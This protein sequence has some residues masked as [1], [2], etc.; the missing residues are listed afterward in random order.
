[1]TGRQITVTDST[2]IRTHMN[3]P[4]SFSDLTVG[5]MV[6]VH[7]RLQ[8]DS[9]L[10]AT[11][12]HIEDGQE[13]RVTG[14][15]DVINGDT[16]VVGGMDFITE[17]TTLYF[18]LAHQP[19]SFPDITTGMV[20]EV[21]A[22]L[23]AD[24]Y[25]HAVRV[26]IEDDPSMQKVTGM[27]TMIGSNWIGISNPN[28]AVNTATV[29]L[30]EQFQPIAFSELLI[31]QTVTLWADAAMMA[32]QIHKTTGTT[33]GLENNDLQALP[34]SFVLGANYPN[35]F[36]PTTTIP[37]AISGSGVHNVEL[38]VFNLL[39]QRVA[40]VFNGQL[41]AGEYRFV[42]DGSTEYGQHVTSGIYFYR[43]TVGN[44]FTAVRRMIL[45]K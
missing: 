19:I 2:V 43:V 6:E 31:G 18:D 42:W 9:S 22:Y 37:L 35:P 39:G 24:G 30:N 7:A 11:R 15:V 23:A 25:Y 38:T 10:T 45:I 41:P 27:I 32:V 5:T 21:K 12:I 14:T 16:L 33:T 44:D 36:N 3:Q 13:L 28:F 20:V 40:T 4:A 26:K 29:I 34:Q 1:V 8:A 17:S